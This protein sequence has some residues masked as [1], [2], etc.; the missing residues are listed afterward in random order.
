MALTRMARSMAARN[1]A[2]VLLGAAVACGAGSAGAGLEVSDGAAP[3]TRYS[4]DGPRMGSLGRVYSDTDYGAMIIIVEAGSYGSAAPYPWSCFN[5]PTAYRNEE[6]LR[7]SLGRA[8][9]FREGQ[10]RIWRGYHHR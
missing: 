5:C 1:A 4:D 9:A 2:A 10:S 7:H 8:N 3:I 6:A